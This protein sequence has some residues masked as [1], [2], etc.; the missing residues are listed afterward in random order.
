MVFDKYTYAYS[1][2]FLS[3]LPQVSHATGRDQHRFATRISFDVGDQAHIYAMLFQAPRPRGAPDF[4]VEPASMRAF[5]QRLSAALVGKSNICEMEAPLLPFLGEST[6][7]V[8]SVSAQ[9]LR[10]YALYFDLAVTEPDGRS[11]RCRVGTTPRELALNPMPCATFCLL[12]SEEQIRAS[13]RPGSMIADPWQGQVR[14][15]VTEP[16][17]T[18]GGPNESPPVPSDVLQRSQGAP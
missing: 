12:G 10:A 2:I 13:Y 17:K 8:V 11:K 14:T 15:D 6:T 3:L 5:Q 18:L 16:P 9:N 1:L 7:S 4:E